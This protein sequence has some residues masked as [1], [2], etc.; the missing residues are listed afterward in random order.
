MFFVRAFPGGLNHDSQ[1][2]E[3]MRLNE[4]GKRGGAGAARLFRI[5]EPIRHKRGHPITE[6][7]ARR[8][9]QNP[10][11]LLGDALGL[12]GARQNILGR[13]RD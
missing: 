1:S 13:A 5:P 6:W 2:F 4:A 9:A 12:A 8:R 3:T 7:I 10:S 11:E